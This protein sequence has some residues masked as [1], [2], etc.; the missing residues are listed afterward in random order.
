MIN[1]YSLSF[2]NLALYIIL[3]FGLLINKYIYPKK[4][5]NLFVL[6]ILISLLAT[7]SI[8]RPGDYQSGDFNPHV[9]RSIA[10]YDALKDGQI[11][12][13][14]PKD[15]NATYGYTVFIFNYN[16]PY[17]IV[18]FFHFIGISFITSMK[19]YLALTYLLSGVFMYLW[20]KN[21]FKNTLAAFT[22]SIFYLFTPYHLVDL[23]FRVSIGELTIFALLPLLLICIQKIFIDYKKILLLY[24]SILFS[25]IIV[26]HAGTGF[27]SLLIVIP[28]IIYN[29]CFKKPF[30]KIKHN[31][32]SFKIFAALFFGAIISSYIF[33]PY[34]LFAKYTYAYILTS[35]VVSF[36]SI[37]DLLFSQW[38][39]GFLFQ[40]HKGELGLLIG[41]TQLFV[42]F[43][44]LALLIKKQFKRMTITPQIIWLALSFLL[45]F[46]IS[47]FSY[48]IWKTFSFLNVIQF[49]YRL[50]LLLTVCISVLA[51][52]YAL[53]LL[54]KPFFIYLL[55]ALTVGYTLLNWG[56]RT[57][58]PA[59]NDSYLIH[60]LPYST[61]EVEGFC[62]AGTTIWGDIKNPWID[63]V[64]KEHLKIIQGEAEWKQTLRTS[65]KH[66]YIVY[67]ETPVIVQENTIYFPGWTVKDNQKTLNIYYSTTT[68]KGVIRFDLSPGLHSITVEY[69][70]PLVFRL[71]KLLNILVI[72]IIFAIIV[73]YN[74]KRFLQKYH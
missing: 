22:A 15:L 31:Q 67:N 49:S 55:L 52:Y 68:P 10:F 34:L 27:F 33:L 44:M 43:A 65:V 35:N 23:H 12:P 58:L 8:F 4:N 24:I 73:I 54:K 63:I 6:L 18:S 59:I 36:V 20:A 21:E 30:K 3:G 16:F 42:L 41:Y 46:L 60:N 53:T 5:I 72:L 39:F 2:I 7:W 38:R 29:C 61:A 37:R 71:L 14:W 19:L 74:T 64:P 25:L 17:Y 70:D 50:L 40:G 62:C 9:Y 28:Y 48:Q 47:P 32:L 66:E 69:K 11:I 45:I 51:G 13:S 57:I 56:Q 26:A 1:Q